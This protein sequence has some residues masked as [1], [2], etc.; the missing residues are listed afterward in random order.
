MTPTTL[1]STLAARAAGLPERPD[2][3]QDPGVVHPQVDAAQAVDDGGREPVDGAGVGDVDGGGDRLGARRRPG[4]A[5]AARPRRRPAAAKRAAIPAPR[6][7]LAPVT[8]RPARRGRAADLRSRTWVDSSRRW[9]RSSSR[10]APARWSP[11]AKWRPRRGSSRPGGRTAAG[12]QPRGPAL[13]AG[14][15]SHRPPGPRPRGGARPPVAGR[16]RRRRGR[17]GAAIQQVSAYPACRAA[18]FPPSATR[19]IRPSQRRALAGLRWGGISHSP[20]P[21]RGAR[22]GPDARNR[23]RPRGTSP[24]PLRRPGRPGGGRRRGDGPARH[25]SW[26]RPCSWRRA[27]CC[28]RCGRRPGGDRCPRVGADRRPPPRGRRSLCAG[29]PGVGKHHHLAQPRDDLLAYIP[30]ADRLLATSQVVEPEPASPAEPR[31]A[32]TFSRPPSWVHSATAAATMETLTATTFLADCSWRRRSG[33]S[34]RWRP[35]SRSCSS[36]P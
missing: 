9:W 25:H 22:A 27:S 33:G 14:G 13:V 28:W 1:T 29:H 24:A 16:G 35:A 21:G 19:R 20:G 8:T 7:R 3:V 23:P 11:T 26:P 4:S 6:P 17:S 10:S 18:T 2:R 32:Q 36:W 12:H 15:D 5:R 31:C 34:R 30:L